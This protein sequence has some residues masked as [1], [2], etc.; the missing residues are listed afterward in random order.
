[1]SAWPERTLGELVD[2][3][4]NR[5]VPLNSRERALRQGRF[6]YYGAQGIV[7]HIDDFRF[8]GRYLLVPEDGENLNSR[9]LPIAY[10]A[11][12]KFWVNN[13]AHVLRGKSG[14]ADD[15]FLKHA[16]AHLNI[17]GWVTGAAQP[18]LSQANL[19]RMPIPTPDLQTQQ[20][21]AG[22]LSAYDDLI[23]VNQRR[24]AILEEMARRLFEEWF[25]WF[26]FPGHDGVALES[27]A[28]GPLPRGWTAK[29][30]EDSAKEI[31]DG[32]LPVD[33]DG[34][35]AYVGLE[36]IPRRST[37]LTET[38]R[39]E[40][41]TSTKLRFRRGDVLF[42]KIRP[43][44]HKVA[45]AAAEGVTSSDT[46]VIRPNEPACSPYVLGLVSS[47]PFVAHAVATSNGTKMPRADWK[48]LKRYPLAQPPPELLKRY[49]DSAGAGLEL[50]AN[51]ARQNACLRAA[52]DL[53]LPKLISG[54]IQVDA[55]ASLAAE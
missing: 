13:H 47:D 21:I 54:E 35:T 43:Y 30:L 52:R 10:F 51:L 19:L 14:V 2:L 39:A 29:A 38:G 32:V 37:T 44:F 17:S 41:V 23:E 34:T 55:A 16:I 46:I 24:I 25:V 22:I 28:Q 15:E 27:T 4:D 49:N 26:R 31:R 7:D 48:V 20:R 9:K 53:L 3:F 50:C 45:F 33:V 1:M 6:P 36:H 11:C 18:K 8:D 5:R 12:G 42:G 40:T